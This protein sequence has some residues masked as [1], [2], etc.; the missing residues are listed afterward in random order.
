MS[1]KYAGIMYARFILVHVIVLSPSP[2]P[3]PVPIVMQLCNALPLGFVMTCFGQ[4]GSVR[5]NTI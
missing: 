2:L 4:W 5:C 1:F 3:I